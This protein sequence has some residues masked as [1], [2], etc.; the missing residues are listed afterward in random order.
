MLHK[1]SSSFNGIIRE[2][3][4]CGSLIRKILIVN[5][6]K[7][8]I[9][10]YIYVTL[11][12]RILVATEKLRRGN[13]ASLDWFSR[14]ERSNRA[15]RIGFS[16]AS[17]GKARQITAKESWM[18]V[19][20][21][22][23]RQFMAIPRKIRTA[24]HLGRR[25]NE[26]GANKGRP[27]NPQYARNKLHLVSLAK[28]RAAL[29]GRHENAWPCVFVSLLLI[30]VLEE[31]GEEKKVVTHLYFYAALRWGEQYSRWNEKIKKKKNDLLRC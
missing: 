29:R 31:I 9:I 23:A 28:S 26:G 1:F 15:L 5:Y 17:F 19:P 12:I 8:S 27:E 25:E 4:H 11:L 2:K 18:Y 16:I 30:Q 22:T 10:R 3:S 14:N 20:T 24:L 21:I 7:F 6:C 13:K